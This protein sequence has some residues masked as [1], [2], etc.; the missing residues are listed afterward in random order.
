MLLEAERAQVG[1]PFTVFSGMTVTENW[2]NACRFG[3]QVSLFSHRVVW[4]ENSSKRMRAPKREH[5]ILSSVYIDRSGRL[6][7]LLLLF[8]AA[9]C[10]TGPVTVIEDGDTIALLISCSSLSCVCVRACVQSDFSSVVKR[11]RGMLSFGWKESYKGR[12]ANWSTYTPFQEKKAKKK[13]KSQ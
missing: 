9:W 13:K 11:R 12:G 4:L 2:L 7:F 5:S 3:T 6:F 1:V 8:F 10:C